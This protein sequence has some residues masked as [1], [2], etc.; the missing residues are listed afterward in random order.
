MLLVLLDNHSLVRLLDIRN[1]TGSTV[2]S[3]R[4]AERRGSK[5][6]QKGL[7]SVVNG[8]KQIIINIFKYL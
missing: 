7:W 8:R 4:T 6:F 5:H 3:F 2:V 1:N